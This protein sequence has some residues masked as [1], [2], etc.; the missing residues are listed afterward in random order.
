MSNFVFNMQL[1]PIIT[2]LV[3][4]INSMINQQSIIK[5][6]LISHIFQKRKF[7]ESF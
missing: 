3:N 1:K 4:I 5:N 6:I 2:Q 7:H